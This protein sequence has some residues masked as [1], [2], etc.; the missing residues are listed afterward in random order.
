MVIQ[1]TEKI[2]SCVSGTQIYLCTFFT[3][4][5]R[6][7]IARLGEWGDL[8]YY[9]DFPRPFFRLR[10][11]NGVFIKGVQGENVCQVVFPHEEEDTA[12]RENGRLD[13]VLRGQA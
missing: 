1:S 12:L 13:D 8:E 2:E 3:T 6:E 5:T 4:W 9:R 7:E 10:S 11:R